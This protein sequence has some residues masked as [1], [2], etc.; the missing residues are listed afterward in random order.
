MAWR[1]QAVFK[2]VIG[3]TNDPS[4]VK[5]PVYT[6][7]NLPDATLW[8]GHLVRASD[9]NG[10]VGAL[11]YSDGTIWRAVDDNLLVAA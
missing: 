5:V 6:I 10:G 1:N 3:A 4:P 2:E 11:C 9:A 7:A 8:E